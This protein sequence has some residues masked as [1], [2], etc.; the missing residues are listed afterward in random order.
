[1]RRPSVGD[2]NHLRKRV[3]G[4]RC[5]VSVLGE[6]AAFLSRYAEDH[7][8]CFDQL[9]VFGKDDSCLQAGSGAC[10]IKARQ[11]RLK[12][13]DYFF[14]RVEYCRTERHARGCGI[15]HQSICRPRWI[16]Y[17][18]PLAHQSDPVGGGRSHESVGLLQCRH[19]WL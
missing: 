9:D 7:K 11:G 10:R 16:T 4:L 5:Q 1:M 19:P 3:L 2:L 6:G 15:G 14:A 8:L 18:D 13:G 12:A 17:L